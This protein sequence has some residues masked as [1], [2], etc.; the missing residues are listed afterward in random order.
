MWGVIVGKEASYKA[1]RNCLQQVC[2]VIN[3]VREGCVVCKRKQYENNVKK[4][5]YMR[6]AMC[7][8]Q[9]KIGKELKT[10]H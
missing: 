9:L 3:S 8:L 5:R 2:N 4:Q 7:G 6:R 1:D 10:R